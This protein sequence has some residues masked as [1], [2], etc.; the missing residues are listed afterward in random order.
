VV[1]NQQRNIDL[2]VVIFV[3]KDV[4]LEITSNFQLPFL[5]RP[6]EVCKAISK[7]KLAIEY[8]KERASMVNSKDFMRD[9][10]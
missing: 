2:T 4:P 7:F 10:K 5:S 6:T 3:L 9:F 1:R 8:K